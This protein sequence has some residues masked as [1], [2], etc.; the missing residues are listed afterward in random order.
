MLSYLSSLYIYIY[1]FCSNYCYGPHDD[2]TITFLLK[3]LGGQKAIVFKWYTIFLK[4][5][6]EKMLRL[7]YVSVNSKHYLMTIYKCVGEAEYYIYQM[8]ET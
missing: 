5:L 1:T 2:Y 7:I 8:N 3:K 4:I 6:G